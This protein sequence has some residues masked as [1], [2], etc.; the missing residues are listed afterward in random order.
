MTIEILHA[1]KVFEQD[2]VSC[3]L[4]Y[5]H[6]VKPIDLELIFSSVRKAGSLLALDKKPNTGTQ[7]NE[8]ILHVVD[9]L[10]IHIVDV[11]FID[12]LVG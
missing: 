1:D 6:T 2:S 12:K 11:R 4:V 9:S 5:L 10:N 3:Y 8:L 7:S